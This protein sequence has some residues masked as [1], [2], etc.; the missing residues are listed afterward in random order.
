MP[1]LLVIVVLVLLWAQQNGGGDVIA[2]ILGADKV[3]T[4]YVNGAPFSLQVKSVGGGNYLEV[5][6]ANAFLAMD[7]AY[8]AETGKRL[9]CNSAF[10][11]IEQQRDLR[12]LYETGG[13]AP[14]DLPGYSNHQKGLSADI[15]TGGLG[16]ASDVFKWLA[17]NASQWAFRNNSPTEPWHWTYLP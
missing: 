12:Q 11:T 2:T 4:G 16:Y 3:V 15:P 6:A 9:G 17:R 5:S 14:A 7:A 1:L 13:G 8:Y 10:R